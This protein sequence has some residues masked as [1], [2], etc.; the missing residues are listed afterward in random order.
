VLEPAAYRA[1]MIGV[2]HLDPRGE[3]RLLQALRQWKPDLIT[4]EVSEYAVAFRRENGERLRQKLLA[5]TDSDQRAHGQIAA[6]FAKLQIPFEV[7]AAEAYCREQGG[8]FHCLD[9]SDLSREYLAEFAAETFTADNIA[10]LL[11]LEDCP[12]DRQAERIYR[13]VRRL[14]ADEPVIPALLGNDRRL[15]TAQQRDELMQQRAGALLRERRPR[16]WVHV[17]GAE[18]LLIIKGYRLF[19]ERFAEREMRRR[20]LDN[21]EVDFSIEESP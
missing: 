2:A 5:L 21:D 15:T 6:L 13:R 20:L 18:H 17:G 11:T 14:L 9:D 3:A 8:A 16:R 12:P 7:T 19:Y 1:L 10:H 4:L